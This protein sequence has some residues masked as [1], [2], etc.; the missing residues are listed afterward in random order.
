MGIPDDLQPDVLQ[1]LGIPPMNA[2]GNGI[3]N[4]SEILSEI[5]MPIGAYQRPPVWFPVQPKTI[6]SF[7]LNAANPDTAAITIYHIPLFIF[8]PNKQVIECRGRRRP[9][10]RVLNLHLV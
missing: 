9:K 7:E 4:D 6:L 5:L 8:Y 1:L 10:I 2:I 3:P